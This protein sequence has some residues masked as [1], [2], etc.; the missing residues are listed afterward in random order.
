MS[1]EPPLRD[2]LV[3]GIS[4]MQITASSTQVEQLLE[5][6]VELCK[7]NRVY[8][9][10]AIRG[11]GEMISKHLLDSLSVLQYVI[12]DN[13]IDV[14]T[15]AGLPGVPVAILRPDISVTL[16]DSNRKKTR[17]LVNIKS[18][19]QLDNVS[20]EHC[21]VEDC[22]ARAEFSTVT[23]R[24]F[25]SLHT[26]VT[27]CEQ[28]CRADGE[29]VAMLGK[30]PTP[31]ELE[32]LGARLLAVDPVSVPGVHGERHIARVRPRLT[33]SDQWQK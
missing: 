12:A 13:M 19:L 29:I 22:V 20:V 8:N 9:L 23:S 21:R 6:L 28:L 25:A 15:G 2:Q 27:Q 26:F 24:A 10:T 30:P 4:A 17:F 5:Y 31:E 18:R 1:I 3:A 32:S 33:G 11:T 16:L 14:G 7:W